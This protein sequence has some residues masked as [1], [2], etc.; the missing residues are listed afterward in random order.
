MTKNP[1][2]NVGLVGWVVVAAGSEITLDYGLSMLPY[3]KKIGGWKSDMIKLAG[4]VAW[5][6]DEILILLFTGLPIQ[7]SWVA[8]AGGQQLPSA[9]LTPG[10]K[11]EKG[12]K[13]KE[14]Q[15]KLKAGKEAIEKN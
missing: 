6:T 2:R 11:L 7:G 10:L 4:S 9:K 12:R 3:I 1:P 15:E 14:S 13:R 8:R 5:Q